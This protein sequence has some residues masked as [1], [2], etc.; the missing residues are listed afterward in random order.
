[1]EPGWSEADKPQKA[2]S[3]SASWCNTFEYLSP[4]NPPHL[5]LSF[6][7]SH[8]TSQ[9]SCGNLACPATC[10]KLRPLRSER[11]EGSVSGVSLAHK[12]W[13][14]CVINSIINNKAKQN[15]TLKS[16]LMQLSMRADCVPL[17][18]TQGDYTMCSVDTEASHD[19]AASPHPQPLLISP[20]LALLSLFPSLPS[21]YKLFKVQGHSRIY[22]HR[23]LLM[24]YCSVLCHCLSEDLWSELWNG[25]KP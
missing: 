9:L 25:H 3:I 2:C 5:S 4:E 21:F 22:W 20:H 19:I 12:S 16:Q 23:Q 6:L 11:E 15:K 1:M 18:D 10:C 13:C 17:K 24:T 7:F 8:G 14:P